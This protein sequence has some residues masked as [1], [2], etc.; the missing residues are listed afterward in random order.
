MTAAPFAEPIAVP[1]VFV[2]ELAKM[3]YLGGGNFRLIFIA[4]QES[5]HDGHPERVVVSRMIAPTEAIRAGIFMAA[6]AIGLSL[7]AELS[8]IGKRCH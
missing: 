5:L 1:D 6:K 7:V 4:E 3:D 8:A 2:T